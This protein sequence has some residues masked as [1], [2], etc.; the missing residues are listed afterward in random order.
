MYLVDNAGKVTLFRY[1]NH[2]NEKTFSVPLD[3]YTSQ[4]RMSPRYLSLLSYRVR[5]SHSSLLTAAMFM[6][7]L[8]NI[9]W[10]NSITFAH[11]T[12]PRC[13]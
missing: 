3:L 6:P 5:K 2:V 8:M 9:M 1:V 10:T 7:N 12:V 13:R 11:C 4:Q